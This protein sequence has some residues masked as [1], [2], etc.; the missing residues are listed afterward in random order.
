MRHS[1]CTD[2]LF[3]TSLP[4][5]KTAHQNA[6]T[7]HTISRLPRDESSSPVYWAPPKLASTTFVFLQKQIMVSAASYHAKVGRLRPLPA[8]RGD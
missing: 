3:D 7:G 2:D 5:R 4:E 8:W 1:W 6:G